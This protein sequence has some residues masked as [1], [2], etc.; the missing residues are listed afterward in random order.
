MAWARKGQIQ[1]HGPHAGARRYDQAL[2][3]SR[4]TRA[5]R[6]GVALSALGRYEEALACFV[7]ATEVAPRDGG[8]ANRGEV[9]MRWARRTVS[10][11]NGRW[12]STFARPSREK[13]PKRAALNDEE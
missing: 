2:T 3:F 4:S 1:R 5:E 13:R 11:I 9:L 7:R 12:R 8:S 6:Q 10:D